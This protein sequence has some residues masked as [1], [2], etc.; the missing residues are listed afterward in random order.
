VSHYNVITILQAN[1]NNHPARPVIFYPDLTII[2]PFS[3]KLRVLGIWRVSN[4]CCVAMLRISALDKPS[5][6][7]RHI[8]KSVKIVS[9]D[10]G[11]TICELIIVKLIDGTEDK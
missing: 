9:I 3:F 10:R 7:S 11:Q 2:S 1:T 8:N 5:D 4:F 6:I